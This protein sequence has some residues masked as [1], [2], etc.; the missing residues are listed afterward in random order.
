MKKKEYEVVYEV[1]GKH[2]KRSIFDID[3]DSAI[4]QAWNMFTNVK[5]VNPKI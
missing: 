5:S 2:Y 1:G 4:K 3:F